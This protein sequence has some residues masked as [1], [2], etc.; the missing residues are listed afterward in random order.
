[1]AKEVTIA[2]EGKVGALNAVRNGRAK[3][4]EQAASQYLRI[5]RNVRDIVGRNILLSGMR[6]SSKK[7]N[8]ALSRLERANNVF[9]NIVRNNLRNGG[10]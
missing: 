3:T 5:Q 2:R 1:M 4:I 10:E 7:K 8:Q 9:N 6:T